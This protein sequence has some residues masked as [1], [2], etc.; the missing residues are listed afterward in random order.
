MWQHCQAA[1]IS[2]EPVYGC[3]RNQGR[4]GRGRRVTTELGAGHRAGLVYG[5]GDSHMFVFT[6]VGWYHGIM[7]RRFPE[8]AE[9]QKM[10]PSTTG[11][12]K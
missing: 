5:D 9:I 3:L 4:V 12:C 8:V 6:G 11:R 10:S 7:G 1:K 2:L